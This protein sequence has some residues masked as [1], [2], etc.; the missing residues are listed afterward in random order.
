MPQVAMAQV[1]SSASTLRNAF[2]PA[3]Y[4]NEC[5]IATARCSSG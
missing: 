1:G 4:Q 2:S 3:E 5:S